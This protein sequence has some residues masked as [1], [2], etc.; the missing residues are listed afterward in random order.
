MRSGESLWFTGNSE[1]LPPQIESAVQD[2]VDET[3]TKT[4]AVIPLRRPNKEIPDGDE[5]KKPR[6]KDNDD[7]VGALIVE[8]IED[9]RAPAEFAQSVD[10][11]CKHSSRALANSMEH[12]SLFLM[13]VW[14]TIGKAKWIV[15]ARTLPKTLAVFAAVMAL[16]AFMCFFPWDFDMEAPGSINPV[17]RRNVFVDREGTVAEGA[18]RARLV[19]DRRPGIDSFGKPRLKC[20]PREPEYGIAD[21]N[22]GARIEPAHVLRQVADERG[23]R[24]SCGVTS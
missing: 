8:Q 23:R 18:G 21:G 12:D 10:M 22:S 20:Q 7:V 19:G 15:E 6:K 4:V 11:V 9:S 5:S 2:Y 24:T 3:H 17:T 14:R 1:D 13:P 16:L